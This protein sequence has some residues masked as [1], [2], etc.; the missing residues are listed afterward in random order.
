MSHRAHPYRLPCETYGNTECSGHTRPYR[1]PWSA[2]EDEAVRAAVTTYGV[3]QWPLV[4]AM[5]PGRTGKQCRERWHNHLD[6]AVKKEP[7]SVR[8]ERMIVELQAKFGNRW[9]DIAKYMPGRTDNAI[10]NH[11]NSVLR[12]GESIDHLR[13]SDGIMPSVFPDG[14][15]PEAPPSWQVTATSSTGSS[16]G[17]A[18]F[19]APRHPLRPTQQEAD[20]IN[21]LLKVEPTSS[22]AAAVG[23]PVSSTQALQNRRAQPALAALLAVIRAKDK[24]ELLHATSALQEAVSTVLDAASDGDCGQPCTSRPSLIAQLG[25]ISGETARQATPLAL[26]P[27]S[28]RGCGNDGC[29]SASSE[30]DESDARA[31]A[32]AVVSMSTEQ[33]LKLTF[34]LGDPGSARDELERCSSVSPVRSP[35]AT[36]A[37]ARLVTEGRVLPPLPPPTPKE[38]TDVLP[39]LM[40]SLMSSLLSPSTLALRSLSPRC[41]SAAPTSARSTGSFGG[42]LHPGPLSPAA[43]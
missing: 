4:A 24:Y 27:P 40:P 26:L 32:E 12:R 7:W 3:R 1:K 43:C 38:A 18:A 37:V 11:F 22:L 14:V 10:K 9:A 5:C 21:A 6:T 15:V 29:S 28:P 42:Q 16:G 36:A 30:G 8:E 13:E 25:E 35:R 39:S 41:G 17:G 2:D 23:Y 33:Q 34:D 19:T 31:L 20:K